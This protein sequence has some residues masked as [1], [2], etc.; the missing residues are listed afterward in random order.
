M[1]FKLGLI[2]VKHITAVFLTEAVGS[3]AADRRCRGCSFSSSARLLPLACRVEKM[4]QQ[5]QT[6]NTRGNAAP[7]H[8][9][10]LETERKPSV[11]QAVIRK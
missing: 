2:D 6:E 5:Q 8:G 9:D 3:P 10:L 4:T 7:R 1:L 11:F